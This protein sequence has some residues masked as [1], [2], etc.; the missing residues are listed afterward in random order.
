[1]RA[2]NQDEVK[3]AELTAHFMNEGAERKWKDQN[4]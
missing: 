3:V 2:A 4:P 1:M